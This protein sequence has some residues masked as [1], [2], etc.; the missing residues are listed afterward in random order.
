MANIGLQKYAKAIKLYEPFEPVM[1]DDTDKETLTDDVLEILRNEKAGTQDIDIPDDQ[2][3]KRRLIR[4][5]LNIRQPL[6]LKK[7]MMRKL[8]ALLHFEKEEK[9]TTYAAEIPN[10]VSAFPGTEIQGAERMALWQGSI[11]DIKADAIVNAANEKLLGCM[12]PLH[13][14]VDNAIHSAAGPML[15]DDCAEIIHRQK[16]DEE[17]GFAKI[18]RGYHLPSTY[19]IHTVGP[20]VDSETPLNDVHVAELISSYQSCLDLAHELEDIRTI[21]FPAISTGVFGFPKQ[22]AAEIAVTTVGNWLKQNDHHFDRIIFNVFSEAD[23][24]IYED[25]FK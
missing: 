25:V 20:A 9:H 17:T 7:E 1:A 14:C 5:L 19:V 15:R 23:K 6:P 16:S 10:A 3:A 13:D 22:R 8:D 21:V 4:A 11:T 2:V 18:T 24:A 12:Q